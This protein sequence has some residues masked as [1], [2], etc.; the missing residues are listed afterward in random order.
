M[1]RLEVWIAR[2]TTQ[3]HPLAR[4]LRSAATSDGTR[5]RLIEAALPLFAE[6]G[7]Q[8]TAVRDICARAEANIAAV[9]YHFGGKAE[10]YRAVVADLAVTITASW[11]QPG[12]RLAD[13]PSA[14]A[15]IDHALAAMIGAADT[16]DR[17]AALLRIRDWE[18]ASPTGLIDDI[19][20][21]RLEPLLALLGEIV[22]AKSGR[23]LAPRTVSLAVLSVF[24][25]IT[26]HSQHQKVCSLLGQ[27]ED[28]V[29]E[30]TTAPLTALVRQILIGGLPAVT[31][32]VEGSPPPAAPVLSPSID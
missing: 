17:K 1:V 16:S 28:V 26:A 25:L 19:F 5:Q 8:G 32:P 18:M 29:S 4:P 21:S 7:F 2:L 23:P 11:P 3:E 14:D 13:Y 10:L 31:D 24:S 9:N 15:A 12:V 27:E 30:A 20:R 6:Q 22:V